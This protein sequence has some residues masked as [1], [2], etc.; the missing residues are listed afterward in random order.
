MRKLPTHHTNQH[1]QLLQLQYQQ[2]NKCKYGKCKSPI[3]TNR[4]NIISKAY[5]MQ[6]KN[7]E[8]THCS[9]F[10]ANKKTPTYHNNNN[11]A[12][13]RIKKSLPGRDICIG[14]YNWIA[15]KGNVFVAETSLLLKAVFHI[16]RQDC[17]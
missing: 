7:Q 5:Y 10:V 4:C 3:K 1:L 12:I 17:P 13:I 16:R 8:T 9:I 11:E 6:A 14:K 2:T 15:V